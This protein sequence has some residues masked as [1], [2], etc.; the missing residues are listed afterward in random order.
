MIMSDRVG[1]QLS[2]PSFLASAALAVLLPALLLLEAA[3]RIAR[4]ASSSIRRHALF[5]FTPC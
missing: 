3:I 4:G 2:P 1:R 5:F